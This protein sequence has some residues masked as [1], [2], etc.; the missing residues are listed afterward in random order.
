MNS[1]QKHPTM[2]NYRKL[3]TQEEFQTIVAKGP[4][5]MIEALSKY[6]R[7]QGGRKATGNAMTGSERVALYR[8]RKKEREQREGAR[9][10]RE[11][12]LEKRGANK[13]KGSR[14]AKGRGGKA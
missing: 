9:Q 6:V 14:G 13:G 5:A 3:L 2:P 10:L 4:A 8:K 7:E 1:L 11:S 12:Q